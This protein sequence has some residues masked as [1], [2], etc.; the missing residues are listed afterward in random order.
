MGEALAQEPQLG[1]QG[2][3]AL[4]E[5]GD[6]DRLPDGAAHTAEAE[7]RE[8]HGRQRI[9]AVHAPME[10]DRVPCKGA[11]DQCSATVGVGEGRARSWTQT[12]GEG[13]DV[14]TGCCAWIKPVVGAVDVDAEAA[15]AEVHRVRR[16]LRWQEH[17]TWLRGAVV[18][19]TLHALV[20]GGAT[21]DPGEVTPCVQVHLEDL[22]GCAKVQGQQVAI[23]VCCY[24]F[25]D[26]QE[27]IVCGV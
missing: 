15:P 14:A 3:L 26:V 20:A 4:A 8:L 13:R 21:G 5:P 9:N 2:Q 6:A 27:V 24:W 17:W 16:G 19:A 7:A 23:C 1:G 10:C 12:A 25:Y 18:I 11:Q 22:W